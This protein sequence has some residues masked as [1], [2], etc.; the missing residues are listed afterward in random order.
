MPMRVLIVDDNESARRT[1]ALLLHGAE[2][3]EARDLTAGATVARL[4]PFDAIVV[5]AYF[6]RARRRGIEWV[7]LL[8]AACP[9]AAIVVLTLDWDA[10]EGE[11][12]MALGALAYVE[13]WPIRLDEIVAAS[14]AAATSGS[15]VSVRA[16]TSS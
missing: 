16:A 13:K 7:P 2:V 11:R 10:A 8:R 1:T 15:T 4:E 14:I 5:E 6:V 12:A 3:A 9:G